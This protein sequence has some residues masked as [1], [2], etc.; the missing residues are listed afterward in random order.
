MVAATWRI[1]RI[2]G[3]STF[4][5]AFCSGVAGYTAQPKTAHMTNGLL[6]HLRPLP[7]LPPMCLHHS[8]SSAP[9]SPPLT[10]CCTAERTLRLRDPPQSPEQALALMAFPALRRANPHLGISREV[11]APS[12]FPRTRFL[13][14]Q[15]VL[16]SR[17]K[18]PSLTYDV[19]K[20]GIALEFPRNTKLNF[21]KS[22][23]PPVVPS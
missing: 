8:P 4:S 10:G 3:S 13:I 2:R 15:K 23:F 5:P 6:R 14:S 16:F 11:E 22:R 19:P 1:Q 21:P 17:K 18:I 12:N 9:D 20:R 7:L